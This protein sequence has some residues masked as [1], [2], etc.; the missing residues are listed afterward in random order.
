MANSEKMWM[1]YI[2]HY[3][4]T[5][6]HHTNTHSSHNH[7]RHIINV[8]KQIP[9]NWYVATQQFCEKLFL[10]YFH[11][12]MDFISLYY[13]EWQGSVNDDLESV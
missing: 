8:V 3:A 7:F 13:Y 10:L 11:Y 2:I 12:C 4:D 9:F 5:H 1:S 6:K